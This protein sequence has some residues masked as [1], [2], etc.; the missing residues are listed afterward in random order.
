MRVVVTGGA[1]DIGHCVVKQLAQEH[2]VISFDQRVSTEL[3]C[4]QVVGDILDLDALRAVMKGTHCVIHLAAIRHPM[5]DPADRVFHVNVMGTHR[6]ADA[7]VDAGVRRIVFASSDSTFG[8]VFGNYGCPLPLVEY[9]PLDTKHPTHPRDPYGLSKL[10]GEEL[11]HSMH[12]R[13]GVAVTCLRYPWVWHPGSY[14]ERAEI[15]RNPA[16]HVGLLWAYIDARDVA[17]AFHHAAER[18]EA[19]FHVILLSAPDT[20]VSMPTL[21][22]VASYLSANVT[23]RDLSRLVREPNRTL[24]DNAPCETLLGLRPA[25]S[26]R[27]E[28]R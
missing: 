20:M 8:F 26:W 27:D 23:V 28:V 6:V 11:L 5:A 9:V 24:V 15:E 1:G 22:L 16:N 25:R 10:V 18:V 4:E 12:R 19:G 17:Q 13:H 21:E 14:P 7:A 3:H 2:E